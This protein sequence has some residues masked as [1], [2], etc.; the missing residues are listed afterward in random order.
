[1]LTADSDEL[2][3]K[4]TAKSSPEIQP[5]LLLSREAIPRIIKIFGLSDSARADIMRALEQARFRIER[6]AGVDHP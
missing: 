3:T 1:M 6:D 4:S 5:R 2:E